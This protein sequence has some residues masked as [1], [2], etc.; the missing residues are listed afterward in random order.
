M[1]RK[2]LKLPFTL[3]RPNDWVCPTCCN[4]MLRIKEDTF[5]KN[6]IRNSRDHSHDEWEP[7][8]VQYVFSCML[9]CKNDLCKETVSCAGVGGVESNFGYD[10][11][12]EPDYSY[13]DFF[14]PK[15]F[16]PHLRLFNIPEGCPKSVSNP[17]NESFR[18]FFSS[19][20]AAS[21][22]VR[23]ALEELL[24]ELKVRR[25]N[26]VNSKQRFMNLHQRISLI[27]PKIA[28]L[29]ENLL[30]IKWLGNAG[31]HGNG[32]ISLDDV[33]DSY[34]QIEHILDEIYTSKRKKLA[35]MAKL[36]NRKRGPVRRVIKPTF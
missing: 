3:R 26:L 5:H 17:L 1:D 8:W 13:D 30:A 10:E 6:E 36:I 20:S 2:T 33:M 12:N 23:V 7:E 22:N 11:N 21:N 14:L 9:V 32:K 27:P 18:H 24:T 15:F 4:G 35:T 19:P 31:S 16:E 28:H 29:K 34:E 25:F